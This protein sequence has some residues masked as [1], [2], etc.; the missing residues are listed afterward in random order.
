MKREDVY[1]IFEKVE[2]FGFVATLV[3][4]APIIFFGITM[5]LN[6]HVPNKGWEL[7]SIFNI[8]IWLTVYTIGA[9][10]ATVYAPKK[11]K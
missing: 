4:F 9:S 7:A 5:I 3:S 11:E 6:Q 10:G 8:L 1:S 2:K